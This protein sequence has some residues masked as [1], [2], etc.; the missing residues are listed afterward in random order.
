M[1]LRE[2]GE[3]AT[4]SDPVTLCGDEA[5]SLKL[6]DVSRIRCDANGLTIDGVAVESD[7]SNG[8]GGSSGESTTGEPERPTSHEVFTK[9]CGC[10]VPGQSAAAEGGWWVALW[11]AALSRRCRLFV[12]RAS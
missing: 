4:L 6:P 2:R 1:V 7:G 10:S 5:S 11:M 8:G 3:D 12:R 9:G